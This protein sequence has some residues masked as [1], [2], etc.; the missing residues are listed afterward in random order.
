MVQKES[1]FSKSIDTSSRRKN[2]E[3][4]RRFRTWLIAQN[5]LPSTVAK[6]CNLCESF[7]SFIGSKPM[8]E[9]VP[10]DC[11]RLHYH[12]SSNEKVGRQSSQW[13]TG[14]SAVIFRFLVH[15]RGC[16]CRSP[17]VHS[18]TR[19]VLTK[20]H[21]FN[22]PNGNY[23]IGQL[24]Q[25]TNGIF[26]GTASAGGS[27]DDGT[28]FS[29]D[30]GLGPFVETLPTAGKV[31]TDVMILGNDLTGATSVT[32]NGTPATFKVVSKSEIMATVPSA[33]TGEIQVT[34]PR[35]TLTSN[36]NFRV[37]P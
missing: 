34:T 26:Y 36:V 16:G 22:S 12:A 19:I 30:V 14:R 15:G 2:H 32:F 10:L 31:G 11:F 21:S 17:K 28:I 20:L 6:Y 33:T 7:C 13:Q 24:F 18:S 25:A 4:V 9:V 37:E 35:G 27:K 1:A 5:Y 23:P 8:T 29:L 3:M